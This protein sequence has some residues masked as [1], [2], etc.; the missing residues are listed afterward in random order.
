MHAYTCELTYAVMCVIHTQIDRS[1][2]VCSSSTP[3]HTQ[4]ATRT[5]L[6]TNHVALRPVCRP[7]LSRLHSATD[8][9]TPPTPPEPAPF[10]ETRPL[11]RLK[12]TISNYFPV[13]YS[14]ISY[15]LLMFNNSCIRILTR[16]KEIFSIVEV[17]GL[18]S[19][20]EWYSQLYTKGATKSY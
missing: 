12:C 18:Y 10:G 9:H 1:F 4:G 15:S 5:H 14:Y 19:V 17:V 20:K 8:T 3:T 13:L 2:S 6:Y 16:I 7:R 11:P